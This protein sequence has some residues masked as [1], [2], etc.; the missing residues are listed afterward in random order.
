MA[1]RSFVRVYHDDLRRDYPAVYANDAAL[2]TWLRLLVLVDKLWPAPAELPRSVRSKALAI[3]VGA[4]LVTVAGGCYTVKGYEAERSHRQESARNAAA[5]RWQSKS[6]VNAYAPAMPRP[7]T[8][9]STSPKDPL[10]PPV[11]K[12]R[13]RK[14]APESLASILRRAGAIGRSDAI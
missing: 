13:N 4:G 11:D 2:A 12:S 14:A 5:M 1:D 7:S 6:N 3:L 8:S 10:N 9:T